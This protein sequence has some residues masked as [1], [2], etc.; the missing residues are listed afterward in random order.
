MK[1]FFYDTEFIEDGRT[2]DLISIGI[3]DNDGREFYAV[4]EE[5]GEDPL[6]GRICNHG[7]LMNNVVPFLPLDPA[8]KM[9]PP[10]LGPFSPYFHLD[11]TG[12]M[13]MPRRMIRNAVRDFLAPE[14]SDGPPQI[15][16]WA[17]FG[18]YDHVVLAQLFGPMIKLPPGVPMFTHEFQQAWANA[19]HPVLPAQTEG[20]H[21]A[22][23][24][25]RYLKKCYDALYPGKI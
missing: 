9:R 16:L 7:W 14:E 18:A 5:I 2:I 17:S 11:D 19:G 8:K 15:E 23:E 21:N 13:I 22:L 12:N 4:A 6:Y 20:E 3:V 1:R 10:G 25:A 24:D